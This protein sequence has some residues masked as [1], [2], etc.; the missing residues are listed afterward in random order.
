M[1]RSLGVDNIDL[2]QHLRPDA[3]KSTT[4]H[5]RVSKVIKALPQSPKE[6]YVIPPGETGLVVLLSKPGPPLERLG[7]A[8]T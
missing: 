7:K 8:F 2:Y 6:Q 4:E 1:A 3:E 5:S